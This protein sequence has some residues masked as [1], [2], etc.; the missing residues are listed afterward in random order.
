MRTKGM[1][2]GRDDFSESTKKLLADRVGWICSFPGCGQSTL[3]PSNSEPLQ[4]INNGVAAHICA[5]SPKGPRYDPKMTKE[6]RINFDNGIWMCR[7]HGGLIDADFKNYSVAQLKQWKIT[8]EQNAYNQLLLPQAS[9]D[10]FS[11]RYS[12]QD[13]RVFQKL[14]QIIPYEVIYKIKSEPFGSFVP[15]EV[16]TPFNNIVNYA[17]DP[18]FDFQDPELKS[19]RNRLIEEAERFLRHFS[20]QSGGSIGGYDYINIKEFKRRDP[21]T[22]LEYWLKYSN[23]T[24]I[25]ASEFCNT[26][27][28][29]RAKQQYL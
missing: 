27:L 13:K 16:I 24:A 17:N 25:L 22:D 10:T 3:G 20:A 19:L 23:D 4:R 15:Q 5:A 7:N 14:N 11:K 6:E 12:D 1:N 2:K 29:L 9:G 8:A 18:L 21:S 28:Q 26:A